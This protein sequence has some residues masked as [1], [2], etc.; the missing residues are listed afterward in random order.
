M[1]KVSFRIGMV[2]LA[3]L[4][5]VF[6]VGA[7]A[8]ALD[9][10]LTP[11]SGFAVT[12]VSLTNY[13]FEGEVLFT[14]DGNST[15]L[16]TYPEQV[17]A[18]HFEVG[19]DMVNAMVA[20]P[21]PVAAGLHTLTASIYEGASVIETADAAFTVVDTTG[22]VGAGGIGGTGPAGPQGPQGPQG[23]VGPQ[24]YIGPS[25]ATG[26]PGV[27]I[28]HDVNNGDG[29]FTLFFTDGTTF[30]TGDL[31]GPDGPPGL[32]GATGALANTVDHAVKNDDGTFTLFFTDGTSFTSEDLT[33]PEGTVGSAGTMSIVGIALGV[34][35]AIWIGISAL[36]RLLVK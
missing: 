6:A 21:Q 4:L 18:Y 16:I 31:T 20:I 2:L 29:T 23:P 36:K 1:K 12:M 13:E 26:G 10:A 8:L 5:L 28:D 19:P 32:T 3:A 14:W 11:S 34:L 7:P 33:G 9:V 30:T 25:G 24:G 27:S 17:Y 15:P 22:P 35:V